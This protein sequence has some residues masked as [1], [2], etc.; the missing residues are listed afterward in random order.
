MSIALDMKNDKEKTTELIFAPLEH[1]L[2][3]NQFTFTMWKMAIM[4][5]NG[6]YV[7]CTHR[8]YIYQFI[9]IQPN[10]LA[11]IKIFCRS[12]YFLSQIKTKRLGHSITTSNTGHNKLPKHIH[13]HKTIFQPI[14]ERSIYWKIKL[15]INGL[16]Y[17][18][19]III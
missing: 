12:I 9:Y 2:I 19:I 1:Y 15:L 10:V 3:I 16:Q 14:A 4:L 7:L 13:L 8:H 18:L 5:G 6:Y 11:H 17:C